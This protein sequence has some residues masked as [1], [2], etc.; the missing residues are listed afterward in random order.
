MYYEF[1]NWQLQDTTI[2]YSITFKM[3][4]PQGKRGYSKSFC[5]KLSELND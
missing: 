5:R 1:I 4:D 2:P 3:P